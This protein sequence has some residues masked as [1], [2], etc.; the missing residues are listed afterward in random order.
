M[1]DQIETIKRGIVKTLDIGDDTYGQDKAGQVYQLK[2]SARKIKGTLDD[3]GFFKVWHKVFKFEAIEDA[4]NKLKG[5][6]G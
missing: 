2:I 3:Y 6:R 4:F 1:I 5:Q